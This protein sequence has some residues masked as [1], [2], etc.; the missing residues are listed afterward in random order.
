MRRFC[1]PSATIFHPN[2]SCG[3]M[4]PSGDKGLT[5]ASALL[6][7]AP[8]VGTV[9]R[10]VAPAHRHR[11]VCQICG[12]RAAVL[13]ARRGAPLHRLRR[14]PRSPRQTAATAK[15]SVLRRCR[16][17]LGVM[18]AFAPP[19]ALLPRAVNPQ[20]PARKTSLGHRHPAPAEAVHA[21]NHNHPMRASH[22][23]S[24]RE[25]QRRW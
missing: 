8:L 20:G 10:H 4:S 13:H 1:R 24:E 2:R 9:G 23:L 21:S 25:S 11:D 6:K 18:A 7:M 15:R 19:H 22:Q 17:D 14:R 5:G 3:V 12:R 16:V